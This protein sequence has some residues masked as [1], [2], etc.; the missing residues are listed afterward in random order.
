[1]VL[2]EHLAHAEALGE[3]FGADQGRQ[4]GVKGRL[5]TARE[6]QEVGIAPDRGRAGLDLP[7][8]PGRVAERGVVVADLQRPEALIAYEARIE[9]VGRLTFLAIECLRGHLGLLW[10]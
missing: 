3:P 2:D 7:A 4:P 10:K 1:V 5:R 8:Q 9:L 6:G